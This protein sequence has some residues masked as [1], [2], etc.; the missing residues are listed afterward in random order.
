MN[1]TG[2]V[3]IVSSAVI[4]LR[5]CGISPCHLEGTGVTG[6]V[7]NAAVALLSSDAVGVLLARKMVAPCNSLVIT[8]MMQ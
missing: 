5:C 3:D 4:S 7:A 6:S 1:L 8:V 2:D